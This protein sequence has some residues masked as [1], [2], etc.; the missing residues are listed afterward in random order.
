MHLGEIAMERGEYEEALEHYQLALD[1]DPNQADSWFDL[2]EAHKMLGNLEEADTSYRRAIE[3]EPENIDLYY[4]LGKMYL[5]NGQPS[6][7][8]QI[9]QEGIDAHPESAVLPVYMATT[10]I[11]M[12][13]FR[14]AEKFIQ[15]AERIDPDL[16]P[17]K[18]VRQVYEIARPKTFSRTPDVRK[19]SR[20]KHKRKR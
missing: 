2:A 20:P 13:D 1:Y 14:Q 5:D 4:N 7:G 19:L 10:Y 8:I 17:V 16:E 6:K 15:M 11:D 12:D 9:I 3:L 18:L